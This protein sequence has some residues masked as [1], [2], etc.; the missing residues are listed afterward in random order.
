MASAPF[1]I[2]L[3]AIEALPEDERRRLAPEIAAIKRLLEE[4]PLWGFLP[5]DGDGGRTNRGQQEFL[6]ILQPIGAMVGG[7]R[8]GKTYV[9]LVDDVIQA[10]PR[11]LVPPWLQPFK[12]WDVDEFHGRVVAVDLKTLETIT[13]ATLRKLIPRALLWKG[14]F[15]KAYNARNGVLQ[16]ETGGW[17]DFKTHDMEVDAFAGAALHHIHFDEEPPGAH[18]QAI[19]NECLTRTIDYDGHIRFTLTPLLGLGWLFYELSE[20]GAL[21]QDAETHAFHVDMEDNPHINQKAQRRVLAK[22][23]EAERQARKSGRFV[24]FAGAIY[25]QFS[26]ER[27]VRQPGIS[28]P[29]ESD[30]PDAKP[31][32]PV[33]M[34]ID[35]G[36][37]HP[38]GLVWAYLDVEDTLAVFEAIKIRGTVGD[39]VKVIRQVEEHHRCAPRWRVIDPSA[40]NRSHATGQSLQQVYAEHGIHTI[41]GMNSREAGFARVQQRLETDRLVVGG[42][43]I[44]LRD[45]FRDYR[46][47]VRKGVS[48]DASPQEPVKIN[49][50]LLD[51]LRY[52]VMSM[53]AKPAAAVEPE[54]QDPARKLLR[55]SI[56][57]LRNNRRV[58]LGGVL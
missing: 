38:T 4:N 50:D 56:K 46:W 18:G 54:D 14:D 26:E 48:D 29:Y 22:F 8:S 16:L 58:K 57:R 12:R 17:F 37:D 32:V 11:E 51:A 3:A 35:P 30:E 10:C 5:H 7:N 28:L 13:L 52:V 15:S 55:D 47:K 19:F 44:D 33:Y 6:S 42:N 40:R 31:L 23:S 53:P 9:G 39:V 27:H 36:L 20:N 41:P 1:E 34:G 24:H 43:L 2:D 45:E 25:P 49:D 21:R